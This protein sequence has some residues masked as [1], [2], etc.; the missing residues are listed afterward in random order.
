MDNDLNPDGQIFSQPYYREIQGQKQWENGEFDGF[1]YDLPDFRDTENPFEVGTYRQTQTIR[2]GTPSVAAWYAD[3]PEDGEYAVYVSYKSLPNSTTDA[4][5][6]VN[7]SGG[8][9]DFLVNQKMGGS[10]WIYLGT[11]PLEKGYSDV[12]P[13]VTLS[14][15]S[16]AAADMVVT[17]DAVK[18]GGGWVTLRV[19]RNVR[20]FI[21]IRLHPKQV[22]L[23]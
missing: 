6:T 12:E 17:A 5:Y 1:I 8:S 9:K 19:V 21:M 22:I 14:N 2:N 11:F 3:I 23:P 13:V 7:Y 16:Q 10:T 18:I 4:L 15:K 20:I